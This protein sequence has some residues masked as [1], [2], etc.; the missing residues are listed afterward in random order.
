L[1]P[2]KYLYDVSMKPPSS[3]FLLGIILSVSFASP[4]LAALEMTSDQRTQLMRPCQQIT[5]QNKERCE[6]RQ[7]ARWKVQESHKPDT[8]FE[9]YDGMDMG[10][11]RL[12]NRLQRERATDN[13]RHWAQTRKT[14]RE[15]EFTE[16]HN[17][18]T[19]PFLTEYREQRRLCMLDTLPDR[20][21]NRCLDR[22]ENQFRQDQST[23]PL[24]APKPYQY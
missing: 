13:K 22:L 23:T 24:P 2:T 7:L 5:G 14:Y 9:T 20:A 6:A 19:R 3:S 17:T 10:Q 16:D 1:K 21:R 4:A 15:Q 12:R 8:A 11:A 18:A